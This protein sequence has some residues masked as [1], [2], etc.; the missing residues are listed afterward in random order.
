MMKINFTHHAEQTRPSNVWRINKFSLQPFGT[1]SHCVP[2]DSQQWETRPLLPLKGYDNQSVEVL[3]VKCQESIMNRD[4]SPL[5]PVCYFV[6]TR[7]IY[8]AASAGEPGKPETER[9][10]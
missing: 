5:V 8:D 3:F 4:L 10:L 6:C 1:L 9:A 2:S 7:L